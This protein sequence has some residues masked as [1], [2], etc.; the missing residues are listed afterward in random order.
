MRPRSI[1][2]PIIL[3]FIGVIFLLN[4]LGHNLPVWSLAWDYWPLLLV[5]L[6]VIGL[7]EVLYQVGRGGGAPARAFGG[8]GIFWIVVLIGFFSWAGHRGNIHIGPFTNG[9]VNILGSDYEYDVNATGASQGVA[10]LVLDNVRGN[11]SLKGEEGNGDVKVSGRKTIRAF[12]RTDADRANQQSSIRIDRQGDE[13]IVH[14][15]EPGGSRMLSVTTDLDI[16]VPKNLDIEARGRTG[17]FTVD[18]VDGSVD[19][20][21]GRGDVRLTNIG[22]DV[23]VD[24]TRTGLMRASGV[25]GNLDINSRAGGDVQIDNIQGQVTING[26]YSGNLEFGQIAKTFHFQSHQS[27]F[28]IEKLP[29]TVTMDL[30]EL[31]I[32]N[33]LGPVRFKTGSRDVHVTDVTDSLEID[34]NRGDVEINQ[35]KTPMPK[36]DVQTKNG[37]ISL[38]IPAGASYEVDGKTHNG[39]TNNEFGEPFQTDRD[40]RGG[41]IKG[42]SGVSGAQVSLETARGT[43]TVRKN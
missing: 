14:A 10:R 30:S 26:E 13:L 43:V 28:R 7:V 36:M 27:D 11:I 8:G 37:D 18:S 34:M 1:T 17:D 41:T 32:N 42:K 3:V 38:G 20:E 23:K 19:V 31:K 40:G 15:E 16:T 29:G 6:G 35:T 2:G 39:D 4:N 5:V 25:K 22:K 24:A 9:G 21:S 33:A 12:S